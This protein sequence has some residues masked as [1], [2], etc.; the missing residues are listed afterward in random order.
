MTVAASSM[1]TDHSLEIPI[2]LKIPLPASSTCSEDGDTNIELGLENHTQTPQ[3]LEAEERPR[4]KSLP[5]ISDVLNDKSTI[6][7]ANM[8]VAKTRSVTLDE[9][10]RL[11][12]S[13]QYERRRSFAVRNELGQISFIVALD[14]RLIHSSA[15]AYRTMVDQ[16]RAS[17]HGGFAVTHQAMET[18]TID[19]DNVEQSNQICT[20]HNGETEPDLENWEEPQCSWLQKL[21]PAYRNGVLTFLTNIRTSP[22]FLSE[23]ISSLS[24]LELTTLTASYQRLVNGESIFQAH[25]LSKIRTMGRSTLNKN[26]TR[27]VEAIHNFNRS[28]PYFLLLYVLF[29]DS[30]KPGSHESV[31]RADTWSTTLAKI[32]EDGKQ[33]SD[34]FALVTLDAF[35]GFREWNL[36]PKLEI[37]LMKIIHEGAF[38]LDPPQ[39]A[40]F[41]QPVELQNAQAAVAVSRFFDESLKQLFEL[42]ISGSIQNSVP[43]SALNFTHAILGK[44]RDPRIR[45]R[46]KT[47][48]T[49]RWYFSSFIST[50]LV[51]PEVSQ[52]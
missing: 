9:L 18:L 32:L 26:S 21:P 2:E 51:Y 45:L 6:E 27:K 28:D 44:I 23:C 35:A 49:S 25:S 15:V 47:F 38:L 14:R 13:E 33:G 24:S 20:D 31:L 16:F 19:C 43:E 46:A 50:L 52:I 4:C 48:I 41:K 17:D 8:E 37:F 5:A 42:L 3:L 30:L 39:A 1:E 22:T 29:D 12:E 11:V 36:K 40:D 34:E 10:A 7:D